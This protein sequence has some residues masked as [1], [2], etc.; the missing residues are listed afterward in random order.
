MGYAVLQQFKRFYHFRP[1]PEDLPSLLLSS[2]LP[3]SPPT[4]A[5]DRPVAV[6]VVGD[7]VAGGVLFGLRR[8]EG[9]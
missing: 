8:G 7:A 2:Q 6:V 1:I 3:P 5:L 4:E 9:V